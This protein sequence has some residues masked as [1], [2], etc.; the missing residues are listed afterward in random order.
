MTPPRSANARWAMAAIWAGRWL[1]RATS[2]APRWP[3]SAMTVA[4]SMDATAS[5][6]DH[7][8]RRQR[9]TAVAFG[10]DAGGGSAPHR[11]VH[12]IVES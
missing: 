8:L 2:A 4:Q 12:L 9:L 5:P 1:L 10:R 7:S 6:V 11:E 3:N